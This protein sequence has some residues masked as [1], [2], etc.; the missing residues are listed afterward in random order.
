MLFRHVVPVVLLT[1]VLLLLQGIAANMLNRHAGNR[2]HRCSVAL[3]MKF[4]CSSSGGAVKG[5]SPFVSWPGDT[6][7]LNAG[8][9]MLLRHAG[10][11]VRLIGV[12]LLLQGLA[13]NMLSRHAGNKIPCCSVGASRAQVGL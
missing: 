7:L 12:W 3:H 1:G 2:V 10:T 5:R 11:I 8:S 4:I 9:N 6:N 13:V